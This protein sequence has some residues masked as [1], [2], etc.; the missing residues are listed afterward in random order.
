MEFNYLYDDSEMLYPY[1]EDIPLSEMII[2]EIEEKAEAVLE[3]LPQQCR[4]IYILNRFKNMSYSEIAGR[5]NI[6]VSTVKTQ[7]GRAFYKF[8]ESLKDYLPL[9]IMIVLF[10]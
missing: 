10:I 8:R 7:M 2:R 1:N 6:S 9:I 3:S 5:L 4:E